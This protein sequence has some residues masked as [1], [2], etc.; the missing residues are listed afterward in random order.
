MVEF[1]NDPVYLDMRKEL[2]MRSTQAE[3]ILWQ[4][5]RKKQML[6]Y[7]FF[8]QFGVLN[9][10]LDFYCPKLRLSIELDGGYHD[11]DEN[12]LFD[13]HRTGIITSLNITEIRFRNEEVLENIDSVLVTINNQINY[14][15][16]KPLS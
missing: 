13:K 8:R 4:K 11:Q 9:Y 12:V 3:D 5:L 2:R 6:G 10:I 7:K 16:K 15:T 1:F 14:I